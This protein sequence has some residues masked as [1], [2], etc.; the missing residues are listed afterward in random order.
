M[1]RSRE[2]ILVDISIENAKT[3]ENPSNSEEILMR[4]CSLSA[5]FHEDLHYPLKFQYFSC[6]PL[7]IQYKNS[8]RFCAYFT[9]GIADR[10]DR[11]QNAESEPKPL[12]TIA[13][14]T[15]MKAAQKIGKFK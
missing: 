3:I 7:K 6:F 5:I 1:R 4:K 11:R 13:V 10:D 9:R 2:A 8:P 14:R 12:R 15:P